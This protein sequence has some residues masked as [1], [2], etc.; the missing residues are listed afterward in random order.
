MPIP[1]SRR[2]ANSF[3]RT[4]VAAGTTTT[5]FGPNSKRVGLI[6]S[7]GTAG[8]LTWGFGEGTLANNVLIRQVPQASAEHLWIEQ[9]GANI[10]GT[11]ICT[12]D[13]NGEVLVATEIIDPDYMG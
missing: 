13:A 11:V 9:W 7:A 4:G 3:F 1:G 2:G 5:V 12:N 8:G 10:Q 6:L